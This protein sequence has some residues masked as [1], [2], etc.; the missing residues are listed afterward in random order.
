MKLRNRNSGVHSGLSPV[1]AVVVMIL[2]VVVIGT[3]VSI[4]MLHFGSSSTNS[5]SPAAG[6]MYDEFYDEQTTY[7][8]VEITLSNT[9]NA[10]HVLVYPLTGDAGNE[11]EITNTADTDNPNRLNDA[12]DTIT[13]EKM[14][15][16]QSVRVIA[17]SE[18]GKKSATQEFSVGYQTRDS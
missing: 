10:D 17:V 2:I 16:D 14:L 12:G 3:I 9:K 13:I 18:D 7:F 11:P 15:E 5:E 4:Y 8:E 6:V 1:V